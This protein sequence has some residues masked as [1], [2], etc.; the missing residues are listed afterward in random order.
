[1]QLGEG[2]TSLQAKRNEYLTTGPLHLP[3]TT[4]SV[5]GEFD[6]SVTD[7]QTQDSTSWLSVPA[8]W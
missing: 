3:L 2:N 8:T 1:M 6:V 7:A 4:I 5:A